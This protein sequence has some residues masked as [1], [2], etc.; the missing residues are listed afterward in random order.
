[1]S[2]PPIP[3]QLAGPSARAWPAWEHI[4]EAL[5]DGQ[6]HR[7]ADLVEQALRDGVLDVEATYALQLVHKA[8]KAGLVE[9]ETR[10][11]DVF[12]RTTQGAAPRRPIADPWYRRPAGVS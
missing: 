7:G 11:A 5:N 6:W 1:M 2:A 3:T 4:W 8:A 10:R 12:K 9:R